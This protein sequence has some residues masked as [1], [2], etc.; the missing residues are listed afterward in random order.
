MH[1]INNQ[2][3]IIIGFCDLLLG[4]MADDDARRL[5]VI[6]IQSAGRSALKELP[7][8]APDSDAT[9]NVS[10]EPFARSCETIATWKT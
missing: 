7:P 5:D 8:T 3:A 10:I 6:Q 2:L 4:D 1:R 9:L